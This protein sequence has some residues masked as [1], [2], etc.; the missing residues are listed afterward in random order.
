[1]PCH[2][3]D[4]LVSEVDWLSNML[5]QACRW[6]T[7]AEIQSVTALDSYIDLW[8]WYLHHLSIDISKNRDDPNE[9]QKYLL[10]GKRLGVEFK[11]TNA[12]ISYNTV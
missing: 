7:K 9:L 10:E 12:S 2:T 1:M 11:V 6:L 4:P 8:G 5:C 3:P